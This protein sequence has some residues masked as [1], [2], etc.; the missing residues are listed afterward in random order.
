[1]DKGLK[2][3]HDMEIHC[4]NVTLMVCF[5]FSAV[6]LLSALPCMTQYMFFG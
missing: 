4:Q 6:Y 5:V 3:M 2:A 1:M